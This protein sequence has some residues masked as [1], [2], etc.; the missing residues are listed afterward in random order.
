MLQPQCLIAM[1]QF[2]PCIGLEYHVPT[3]KTYSERRVMCSS[4]PYL[5]DSLLLYLDCGGKVMLH[6]CYPSEDVI[7]MPQEL[8]A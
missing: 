7:Q 6:G 2:N 4:I 5:L 3:A 8:A 1:F